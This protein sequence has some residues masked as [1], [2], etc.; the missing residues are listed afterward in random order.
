MALEQWYIHMRQPF[1]DTQEFGRLIFDG[2]LDKLALARKERIKR[3]KVLAEKVKGSSKNDA[4][5]KTKPKGRIEFFEKFSEIEEL[6]AEAMKNS[7][8][9]RYRDSFLSASEK[10]RSEKGINYIAVIQGLPADVSKKGTV[11]LQ[12]IVDSFCE[13]TKEIIPSLRLFI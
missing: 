12:G 4:G 2:L 10:A 11:W 13:K 7:V 6:F 3:L 5:T 8:I 9:D 1:F